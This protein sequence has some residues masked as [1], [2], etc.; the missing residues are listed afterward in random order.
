[1]KS[2]TQNLTLR[3]DEEVLVSLKVVSEEFD[4]SMQDVLR[5]IV[6]IGLPVMQASSVYVNV[7]VDV[8]FGGYGTYA[9]H[10][11]DKVLYP[12]RVNVIMHV[13]KPLLRFLGIATGIGG[14]AIL[15]PMSDSAH[16]RKR[17]EIKQ[18]KVILDYANSQ[19]LLADLLKASQPKD[20]RLLGLLEEGLES[21]KQLVAYHV[22]RCAFAAN[23]NIEEFRVALKQSGLFNAF[24]ENLS[25]NEETAN[26]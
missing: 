12:S 15:D 5:S 17:M 26:V 25:T 9:S 4:M 7:G 19:E 14:S 2:S 11:S 13:V 22:L 10:L 16:E 8:P 20:E 6:S 21:D 1:M 3:V 23:Q 18:A 24:L